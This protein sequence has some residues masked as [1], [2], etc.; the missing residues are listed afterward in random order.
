[1]TSCSPV[2]R[3][4]FCQNMSMGSEI[5]FPCSPG[6]LFDKVDRCIRLSEEQHPY[7]E[8]LRFGKLPR[9]LSDSRHF[10][11]LQCGW[12]FCISLLQTEADG[13]SLHRACLLPVHNLSFLQVLHI[14][15]YILGFPDNVPG[16]TLPHPPGLYAQQGRK[17]VHSLHL[18]HVRSPSDFLQEKYLDLVRNI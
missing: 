1:M 12:C 13:V 2:A 10:P 17:S 5:R 6:L 14:L 4:F 3:M 9:Y 18:M 15:L 16:Y 8:P 11:E 7:G